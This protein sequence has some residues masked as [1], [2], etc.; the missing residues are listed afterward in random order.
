[1][2]KYPITWKKNNF[3]I[4]IFCSIPNIATGILLRADQAYF[5]IDPGDGILRDLN[6]EI[7]IKK[8]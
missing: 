5:V 6:K 4:K 2:Q 1:M 3:S 8:S 7:G